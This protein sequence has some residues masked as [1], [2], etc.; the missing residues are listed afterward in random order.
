MEQNN[1]TPLNTISHN[2]TSN[3]ALLH[4]K[5]S[6]NNGGYINN[7][8]WH[9]H[10]LAQLSQLSIPVA[11][12]GDQNTQQYRVENE[13]PHYVFVFTLYFDKLQL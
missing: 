6:E 1:N 11:S 4:N 9:A 12:L 13:I 5:P 3:N 10:Q 8:N 7:N 2:N